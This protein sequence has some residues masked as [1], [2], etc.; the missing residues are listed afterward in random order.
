M[1]G[2][3]YVLHFTEMTVSTKVFLLILFT[4]RMISGHMSFILI[5]PEQA[6]VLYEVD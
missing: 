4:D 3:C 1:T 2:C 5:I 6:T